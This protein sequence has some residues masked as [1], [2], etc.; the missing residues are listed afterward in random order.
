MKIEDRSDAIY[1]T[2]PLE[3]LK[4]DMPVTERN[5]LPADLNRTFLELLTMSSNTASNNSPPSSAHPEDDP[6]ALFVPL[7]AESVTPKDQSDT[8]PTDRIPAP[9]QTSTADPERRADDVDRD[10]AVLEMLLSDADR[11]YFQ[12]VVIPGLPILM[13]SVPFE[14]V[15]PPRGETSYR[16]MTLSPRMAELI[17]QGYRTGHPVRVDLD[18]H[19]SVVLKIRDGRVSAEFVALDKG[20]ALVMQQE[21]DRLRNRML[22]SEFAGRTSGGQSGSEPDAFRQQATESTE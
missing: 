7:S 3:K 1:R 8:V 2:S 21:L 13:G 19:S 15:F 10:R 22:L 4:R 12:Q 5:L 14:R 20:A 18:E 16:G 6:H 11:Q 9:V 17:E